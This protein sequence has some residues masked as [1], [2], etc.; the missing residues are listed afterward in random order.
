MKKPARQGGRGGTG[1]VRY[2]VI[3]NE[4]LTKAWE[5]DSGG[6]TGVRTAGSSVFPVQ[7]FGNTVCNITGWLVYIVCGGG[8][9]CG[10]MLSWIYLL[11]V[12]LHSVCFDCFI[13]HEH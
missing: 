1:G 6:G 3:S 12:I 2:V 13:V 11:H 9:Q 4:R 5:L 7:V 10:C 8:R